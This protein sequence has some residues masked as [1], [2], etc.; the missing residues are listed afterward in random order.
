MLVRYNTKLD[1]V[2]MMD[3]GMTKDVEEVVD[4]W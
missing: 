3:L 4:Q 1:I 2:K